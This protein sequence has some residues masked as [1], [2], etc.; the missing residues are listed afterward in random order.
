MSDALAAHPEVFIDGA[1]TNERGAELVATELWERIRPAVESAGD[2]DRGRR[3]E[4][5]SSEPPPSSTSTT[6]ADPVSSA[7]AIDAAASALDAAAGAPCE[8]ER[9]KVWLGTLRA[10]DAGEATRIGRLTQRFLDGLADAAPA[11]VDDEAGVVRAVAAT[12]PGDAATA[13][14]DPQLPLVPQLPVVLDES[15]PF[16]RSFQALSAGISTSCERPGGPEG[17]R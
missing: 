16:L 7:E 12:L 9:W 10:R 1:H 8:L 4:P 2:G 5:R 3:A 14:Y 15:S 17:G 6:D 11:D 13:E